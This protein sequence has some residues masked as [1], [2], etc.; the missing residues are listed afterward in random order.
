MIY[1]RLMQQISH[2]GRLPPGRPLP[3]DRVKAI[4]LQ[5]K[6]SENSPIRRLRFKIEGAVIPSPKVDSEQESKSPSGHSAAAPVKAP[7]TGI[8]SQ[9]LVDE[10]GRNQIFVNHVGGL[11]SRFVFHGALL[12]YENGATVEVGQTLG[13][14]LP[15]SW[16]HWDLAQ[17]ELAKVAPYKFKG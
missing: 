9:S 17:P 16:V 13:W 3:L 14:A 11:Q 5:S 4:E 12:G 6:E 7:L 10:E 2:Q 8:V 1:D 15:E